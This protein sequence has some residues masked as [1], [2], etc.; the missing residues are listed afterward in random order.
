VT[1]DQGLDVIRGCHSPNALIPKPSLLYGNLTD[2]AV[3][4][5]C[6]LF[7]SDD[8]DHQPVHWRNVAGDP[9]RFRKELLGRL[10][11]YESKWRS[12]W[13]EMKRYRDQSVAHHDQRRV[14]IK[15]YPTFDLALESAY[16][17]YDFLVVE[18]RKRAID[19]HPRDL[20]KY[21]TECRPSALVGQNGLI[22]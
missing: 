5:W 13:A 14:E 11:I 16:F 15:T 10:G 19:Q 9:E 21:A 22:V 18:L 2:M 6:K 8:D 12:Y 20:R 3:L 7:G 17:Y 4:E 1:S